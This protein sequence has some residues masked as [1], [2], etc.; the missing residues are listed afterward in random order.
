M[1]S[2]QFL[3]QIIVSFGIYEIYID[4]SP[5]GSIR[6]QSWNAKIMVMNDDEE[7]LQIYSNE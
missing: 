2:L 1:M 4:I 7:Y 6:E 5:H 3:N